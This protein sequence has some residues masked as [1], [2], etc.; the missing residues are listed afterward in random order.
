MLQKGSRLFL[1]SHL[2]LD[3]ISRF[4]ELIAT[5]QA[6]LDDLYFSFRS[7]DTLEAE[8]RPRLC[9]TDTKWPFKDTGCFKDEYFVYETNG[10]H[11]VQKTFFI[12]YTRPIS[13][14]LEHSRTLH[15]HAFAANTSHPVTTTRCRSIKWT[16]DR[17]DHPGQI[18]Q[19]LS[20]IASDQVTS[21]RVQCHT[22]LV[23]SGLF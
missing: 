8:W 21:F 18:S 20:V 14:L 15:N 19:T 4:Q 2:A 16:C 12:V 10:I 17:M 6:T 5:K 3:Q 11:P 23:R 13:R 7:P 1:V 9:G 22:K